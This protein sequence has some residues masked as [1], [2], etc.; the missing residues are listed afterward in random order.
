MKLLKHIQTEKIQDESKVILREAVRIIG[1]DENHL[2]PLL[3]VSNHN[4]HKLPGGG[5][6]E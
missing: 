6:D 4:Y 2:I 3:F 1:I 5:I